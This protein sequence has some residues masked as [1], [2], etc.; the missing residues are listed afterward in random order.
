CIYFSISKLPNIRMH[1]STQL[2]PLR[3]IA[4]EVM[5]RNQW[6]EI[7]SRLHLVDNSTLDPNPKNNTDKLF[8]VR[9]MV[10]HLWSKFKDIPM[11]QDLCM[12][13]QMIPFKGTSQMKQYVAGKPHKWG[14]K[15]F[16]LADKFGM[17]YDFIPYTGKIE[18]VQDPNVP[19]RKPSSNIVLH[20]AETVPS[21]HNQTLFFFIT[22]SPPY[23]CFNI[24]PVEEYGVVVQFVCHVCKG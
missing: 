17:T 20:L 6:E 1:W 11:T 13:E 8:N 9:P 3:D 23:L 7:K 2:G 21:F 24:L 15:F 16:I 14:Y 10:D 18:P 12:D 19:D 22:G 4:S 5:S